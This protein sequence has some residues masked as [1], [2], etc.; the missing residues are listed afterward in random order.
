[1]LLSLELPTAEI[2]DH[3]AH[4]HADEAQASNDHQ[5]DGERRGVV[6]DGLI[7]FMLAVAVH[8]HSVADVREQVVAT[9]CAEPGALKVGLE[10]LE[11]WV[12]F[13]ALGA[14]NN[15]VEEGA[16]IQAGR[17]ELISHHTRLH[18]RGENTRVN[19][20]GAFIGTEH[21]LTGE[22][23]LIQLVDHASLQT[24]SVIELVEQERLLDEDTHTERRAD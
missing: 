2:A 6:P 12:V 18:F 20:T 4:A 3:E 10:D 8:G 23:D 9:I 15:A 7:D 5:H 11:D 16:L 1:M 22:E 14:V 17:T 21:L 24:A 13:G 19:I